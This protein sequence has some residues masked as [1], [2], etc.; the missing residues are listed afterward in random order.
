MFRRLHKKWRR[1]VNR[2]RILKLRLLGARVGRGVVTY[3][4]FIIDGDARQL[5]IGD[6]CG[7]NE[8]VYLN[9]RDQLTL[10]QGVKLSPYV[11]IHTGSLYVDRVPRDHYSKPVVIED[12][13]WLAS[14]VVVSPGVTIGKNAC[15]AAGSVVV[16][17]LKP[18]WFYGGVPARPIKPL[19]SSQRQ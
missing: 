7:L 13:V 8:G 6:D 9:C 12:N 15:V 14:G 10:G 4:R 11:Q 3:G 16:R 19:G 5:T 1:A 17:D 2:L 18:G